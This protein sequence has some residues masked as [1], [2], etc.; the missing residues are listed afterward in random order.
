MK[1][2]TAAGERRAERT[3]IIVGLHERGM[4]AAEIVKAMAPQ[5]EL[6]IDAV[7]AVLWKAFP[8]IPRDPRARQRPAGPDPGKVCRLLTD[9]MAGVA[10]SQVDLAAKIATWCK[11]RKLQ[12]VSL[13]AIKKWSSARW[14]GT[15]RKMS[16][17]MSPVEVL[18]RFAKA[19]GVAVPE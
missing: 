16:S 4:T 17:R 10:D 11:G 7:K 9:P 5:H 12:P 13:A 1:P 6:T 8:D 3:K 19:R 15:P 14:A 18:L 2:K